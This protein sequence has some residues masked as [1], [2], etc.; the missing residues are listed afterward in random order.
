MLRPSPP[1]AN[2]AKHQMGL[3]RLLLLLVGVLILEGLLRK[4][5]P[6]ALGLAIFFAKDLLTI[7]LWACIIARGAGE[8]ARP[9]VNGL[10]VLLLLLLPC[11]FATL[12]KDVPLAFFG[13][14]Q[15]L[16]FTGVA[17]AVCGAFPAGGRDK[18]LGILGLLVGSVLL[19][20]AVAVLQTKLPPDHWLN[21]SVAGG[22]LETFTSA[23]RLRVASTFPFVAQYSMYLNAMAYILPV[24]LLTKG[25]S[26][27]MGRFLAVLLVPAFVVGMFITGSRGSVV[28]NAAILLTGALLVALSQGGRSWLILVLVAGLGLG[29]YQL[30]KVLM[31][32]A[33]EL[34]EARSSGTSEQTHSEEMQERITV[35][36]TSWMDDIPN[37]PLLGNGLGL[38]SNG[39]EKLSDYAAMVRNEG[40]WTE[41]DQATVLYEG[42]M[43]LF[44]VWYGFR[45]WVI[46]S[47]LRL[48]LSIK[49]RR[50]SIP[51][52]FSWGYILVIGVTGTLSIQPPMAVWWWLAVGLIYCLKEFDRAG[53]GDGIKP[54]GVPPARSLRNAAPEFQRRS[55]LP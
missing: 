6:G 8:V 34:Y 52:C 27:G 5:I 47:T 49:D 53:D 42:G 16:L 3:R 51:A 46:V 45:F 13:F 39:V 22:S 48:I 9:L 50:L 23:G 31:P 28:G 32:E 7:A 2:A 38:M 24:F 19:T 11:F 55:I 36:L 25:K 29:G 37:T 20:T 33:F 41:T 26:V 17:V 1:P 21:L 4:M 40:F 44:I 14:K 12:I 35:S 10:I 54:D 43:Y 30:T 15:H 18:L